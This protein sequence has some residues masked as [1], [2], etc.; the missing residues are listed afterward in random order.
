LVFRKYIL[1]LDLSL[2]QQRS[3][4]DQSGEYG[5]TRYTW[6]PIWVIAAR[7]PAALWVR[8]LS[9]ITSG[10]TA[11]PSSHG[12]VDT[13]CINERKALRLKRAD[14]FLIGRSRVLDPLGIALITR[15]NVWPSYFQ[16][17]CRLMRASS[18]IGC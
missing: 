15:S 18:S 6:A 11:V 4:G 5:G 8:R 12:E 17:P 16:R 14:L 13:R 3:I 7:M 2:D 9:I 10:R 1:S